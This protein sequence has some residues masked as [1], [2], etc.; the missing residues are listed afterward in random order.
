MKKLL[1]IL[2]IP[3]LM[4]A[5]C[6]KN[7][8]T[9]SPEETQEAIEVAEDLLEEVEDTYKVRGSCDTIASASHCLDYIGSFWTEE[10]MKLNC[11]GAGTFKKT[12]CPYSENGGCQTGAG[13][14]TEAV[15]WSY[16]HGGK[17]ISAE[18]A[19]YEAKACDV[20]PLGKWVTPD[21]LFLK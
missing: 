6:S 13:T 20:N 18:E 1:L 19:K 11:Q 7:S 5:G 17:P 10:Q 8:P 12:T 16:G 3:L 14:I 2:V 21:Q 15:V 4:G 9:G